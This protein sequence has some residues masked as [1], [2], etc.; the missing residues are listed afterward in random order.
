MARP[1]TND[2]SN[3]PDAPKPTSDP[4]KLDE[5]LSELQNR[6]RYLTDSYAAS[7]Q[8]FETGDSFNESLERLR[9]GLK[10][11]RILN[12]R[13]KRLHPE[14]ELL[15]SHHARRMADQEGVEVNESHIRAAGE[16]VV[17]TIKARRGRP[18]KPMLEFHVTGL[19]AVVQEFSGK[20]VLSQR[21]KDSVYG[22]GFQEGVNQIIPNIVQKWDAEVTTTQLVN[23]VQN[24]R[25][26]YAGKPLRFQELFPLYGATSIDGELVA[27]AGISIETQNLNIP[28]Y[29][30]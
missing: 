14:I 23:M 4:E 17:S 30:P 13:G 21:Y 16:H 11:T 25:K 18:E 9:R 19:M 3:L 22:P 2:P 8:L 12:R 28:I 6:L 5:L 20:P 1:R 29:C 27:P 10:R 15:L 7:L 24:I 26:N